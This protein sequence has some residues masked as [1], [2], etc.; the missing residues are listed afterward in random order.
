MESLSSEDT[1]VNYESVR[2]SRKIRS[3]STSDNYRVV[4]KNGLE[5]VV[6]DVENALAQGNA[7][8]L[9]NV[10]VSVMGFTG[11]DNA[12]PIA[13]ADLVM[14]STK[15]L[16]EDSKSATLQ[17]I[18]ANQRNHTNHI[19]FG[20]GNP[21]SVD[22][23][24]EIVDFLDPAEKFM[25]SYINRSWKCLINKP[26]MWPALDPC[27]VRSFHKLSDMRLFLVQN[28]E[29]FSACK[30]LQV[31]SM[32]TSTQLFKD[33]FGTMPQLYQLSLHNVTG[34]GSLRHI[35]TASRRPDQLLQLSFGL[36]TKVTPAEVVSAL[37]H[38][39]KLPRSEFPFSH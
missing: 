20:L 19:F 28:S 14:K 27:P 25:L 6:A 30:A 1:C 34:S 29:K 21:I 22:S 8:L 36:S 18:A 4:A 15:K 31:P 33:I 39:G 23:I 37:K 2:K 13:A 16:K 17:R 32:P 5:A 10:M 11:P 3:F 7:Q 38:F 24:G 35:V 12:P 26:F 9:A